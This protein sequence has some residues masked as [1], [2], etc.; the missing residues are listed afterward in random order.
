MKDGC[1]RIIYLLT[2]AVCLIGGRK[3][4]Q[5]VARAAHSQPSCLDVEFASTVIG[6]TVMLLQLWHGCRLLIH[7]PCFFAIFDSPWAHVFFVHLTES[8]WC[9]PY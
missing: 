8:S 6:H 9:L 4:G 3:A 5:S 1:A 7:L 2:G